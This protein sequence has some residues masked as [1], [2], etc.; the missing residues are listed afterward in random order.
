MKKILFILTLTILSAGS[1]LA[2]AAA[3]PQTA[4]E[5]RLTFTRQSGSASNQFA[6]WIEDAQGRYVKTL[7]ATRWT[8]NGGFE[9]R[10]SSIPL[11]VRVSGLAGMPRD[12][13]DAVSGATPRNGALSYTWDG[14]DSRG[15]AV[16]AGDYSVVIEGTLRW[17]NQVYYRAPIRLG[18]GNAAAR[19]NVEYT[20]DRDTTAE[21]AMIR[22]VSVTVLR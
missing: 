21:R 3:S 18:S 2:Q 12:Q 17:E 8:A 20:G 15:A 10:P 11:W 16:S 7:Y 5:V 9:R 13:I 22:D 19:V 6:V 1:V 4:L 14:T